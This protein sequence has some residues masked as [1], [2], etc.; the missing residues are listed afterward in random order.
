MKTSESILNGSLPTGGIEVK[1]SLRKLTLRILLFY[2]LF[3]LA[4]SAAYVYIWE[5]F[6][7]YRLGDYIVEFWGGYALAAILFVTVLCILLQAVLLFV[8]NGCRLKGLRFRCNWVS[9]GFY[10]SRTSI[11]L[12]KFRVVLLLP[13]I[14]LGVLPTLHGFCGGYPFVYIFGLVGIMCAL[15]DFTLWYRLRPFHDDDLYQAGRNDL[16]CTIIK[17]DFTSDGLWK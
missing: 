7:S 17:R 9:A 4:G 14:L 15:G 6:S 2:V 16:Q 11:P 1:L 10:Y 13:G 8:A 12:K 3:M 5:D